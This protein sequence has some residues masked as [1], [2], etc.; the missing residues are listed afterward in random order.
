MIADSPSG[1][2]PTEGQCWHCVY[3]FWAREG[4]PNLAC[5]CKG[6]S[7]PEL[8]YEEES[9]DKGAQRFFNLGACHA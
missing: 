9:G 1:N 8:V 7:P 6:A 2:G 5:W 4:Q 3:Q